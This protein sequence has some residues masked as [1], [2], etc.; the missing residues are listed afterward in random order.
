MLPLSR[1]QLLPEH[2][3]PGL[4]ELLPGGSRFGDDLA[5][6]R[7]VVEGLLCEDVRL[8]GSLPQAGQ[9]ALDR[10]ELGFELVALASLF[11]GSSF[12]REAHDLR[13]PGE[14]TLPIGAMLLLDTRP[15]S[16]RLVDEHPENVDEKRVLERVLRKL[17]SN[18]ARR[19]LES[20]C[21]LAGPHARGVLE[22]CDRQPTH[23]TRPDSELPDSA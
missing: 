23:Q 9:V 19:F 10:V 20:S 12:V 1:R 3:R 15:L 13:L 7:R 22:R 11:F 6:A 14:K 18:G 16:R 2:V 17:L 4:A 5:G 21:S 8:L